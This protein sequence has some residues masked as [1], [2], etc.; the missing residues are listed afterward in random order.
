M[1]YS[2]PGKDWRKGRSVW[3]YQMVKTKHHVI[4][5]GCTKII[6]KVATSSGWCLFG[7]STISGEKVVFIFAVFSSFF[8]FLL[9][10]LPNFILEFTCMCV[11]YEMSQR[12]Q[13]HAIKYLGFF[14]ICSQTLRE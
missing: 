1:F 4:H 14:T 9:Y 12:L 5:P 11:I 6:S 8:F 3:S 7:H 2:A 13:L 10:F